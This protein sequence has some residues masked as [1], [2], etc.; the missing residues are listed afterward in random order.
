MFFSTKETESVQKLLNMAHM[1]FYFMVFVDLANLK[2]LYLQY[3]CA[4]KKNYMKTSLI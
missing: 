1:A 4:T 2:T 3:E